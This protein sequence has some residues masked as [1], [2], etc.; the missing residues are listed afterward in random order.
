[1]FLKRG[2][3]D[4]IEHLIKLKPSRRRLMQMYLRRNRIKHRWT[5]EGVIITGIFKTLFV[6]LNWPRGDNDSKI[7]PVENQ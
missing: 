5:D 3:G 2:W 6:V 4:Q 1:V 7:Y